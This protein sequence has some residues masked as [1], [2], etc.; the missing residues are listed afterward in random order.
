ML[1]V[2]PTRT[3]FVNVY[4][5]PF[6]ESINTAELCLLPGFPDDVLL[7]A[8]DHEDLQIVLNNAAMWVITLFMKEDVKIFR[9]SETT[10]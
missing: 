1:R 9:A 10:T 3:I 6:S 4:R 8:Q 5:D 2:H 7:L